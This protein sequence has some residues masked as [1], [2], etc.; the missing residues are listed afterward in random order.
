[1]IVTCSSL[2]PIPAGL[3]RCLP[4]PELFA[5]L[6]VESPGY[7][8]KHSRLAYAGCICPEHGEWIL[9]QWVLE[10][11]EEEAALLSRFLESLKPC[12]TLVH[13][14]GTGFDL[15]LIRK[16]CAALGLHD[17]LSAKESVDVYQ[18]LRPFQRLF[19]LAR[20]DERSLEAYLGLVRG[21]LDNDLT[22]LARIL[23]LLYYR[24]LTEGFFKA[25]RGRPTGQE[26]GFQF[27]ILLELVSP[28]PKAV[29][30]LSSRA[31]LKAEGRRASLLVYGL[32]GTL[33]YFFADYKNYYYLPAEDQAVHRSVAAYVDKKSRVPAKAATCYLKKTGLFL[34]YVSQGQAFAREYKDHLLWM[35][36]TEDWAREPENLRSYAAS[37]LLDPGFFRDRRSGS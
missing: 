20:M 7:A 34:P 25:L 22:M 28:L 1:M 11:K 23:P 21:P 16:R 4:F 37:L 8:R 26:G 12:Q 32:Q 17:P 3:P 15:P 27:E 13:F 33:K 35:L 36:Y 24:D 5:L 19:G 14:G 10:D 31:Y 2:G 18:L 30:Y 29:S 9:R 6:D